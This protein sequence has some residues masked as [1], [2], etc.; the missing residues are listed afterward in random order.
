MKTKV[1]YLSL[2]LLFTPLFD[3]FSSCSKDGNAI[4]K[5]QESKQKAKFEYEEQSVVLLD[6]KSKRKENRSMRHYSKKLSDGSDKGLLTF[7]SPNDIKGSAVLNWR[8][9]SSDDQWVYLPALKKLQRIAS[10]SKRKYFMGTDFTYADLD[11]EVLKNHNYKCERL[12]TCP[13][14]KK[15]CYV[16]TASPKTNDIKRTTGYTKRQ[17][18]VEEE[19]LITHK[20]KY[21]NL[22]G[23]AFKE[24]EY[25][26]WIK[27][28]SVW[29]PNLA[30]MSRENK[31]K[32]YIKINKRKLN[33]KIDDQV[34]SKRFVEK[35]MH[36][37]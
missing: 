30:V 9:N 11:G 20:I 6:V 13:G 37:K 3:A 33:E 26:K 22:K 28:G 17:L 14:L 23:K 29:R 18:W 19:R 34:F 24:A 8:D 32:T 16:I 7:M 2:A 31:H 10:G 36:I 35:E 27:S 1:F 15:K 21:F 25:L 5:N 4:M 12:E